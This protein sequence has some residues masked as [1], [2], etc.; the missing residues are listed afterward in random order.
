MHV[1][2]LYIE[3]NYKVYKQ[4]NGGLNGVCPAC[5]GT[6]RFVVYATTKRKSLG[7][8][9]WGGFWCRQCKIGG[10][11]IT[12]LIKFRKLSYP[13]ALE[14]LGLG[15]DSP[16]P[17]RKK[18]GLPSPSTP[19]P[20]QPR[21][22][23][24]PDIVTDPALWAD[25]ALKF[26]DLCHAALLARPSAIDWLARRGV[27]HEVIKQHQLGFCL[28]LK[29]YTPDYRQAAAWGITLPSG[30]K[31][32][33][34][35]LNA[36][37]IIPAFDAAGNIHRINIRT[38][39][40]HPKYRIVKGSQDFFTFHSIF[41]S[42]ADVAMV[43]ESEFDAMA[44]AACCPDITCVP[45]GTVLAQPSVACNIELRNKQLILLALD[46]DAAGFAARQWWL[47]HYPQA[48]IWAPPEGHKDIGDAIVSDVD[49]TLW[50]RAGVEAHAPLSLQKKI[51]DA[52]G[53]EGEGDGNG[54]K[55]LLAFCLC[56]PEFSARL[57]TA[58]AVKASPWAAKICQILADNGGQVELLPALIDDPKGLGAVVIDL[59][60]VD[61]LE[62]YGWLDDPQPF[63]SRLFPPSRPLEL[64]R[65][66]ELLRLRTAGIKVVDGFA[67]MFCNPSLR[68][69]TESESEEVQGLLRS[70]AV[71]KYLN[72]LPDGLYDNFK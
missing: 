35:A 46:N 16:S 48:K 56:W 71:D 58:D 3:D 36:G 61:R 72:S 6:D 66:G 50:L 10:D 15:G 20:W 4:F 13:D 23:V 32:G 14:Y 24:W 47:D 31:S 28:G 26:V 44:L 52:E 30:H 69:W 27:D 62:K 55:E 53:V 65:L 37:L 67:T 51:T 11:A 38:L 25:H 18:S 8:D 2:E 43:V 64:D 34:I 1:T 22:T 5:G 54:E 7:P 12:Y 45:S 9:D 68:A 33:A 63:L 59:L 70:A 41:N 17:A 21:P 60:Y 40:G 49:I 57:L 39:S 29:N 19:P 42:G